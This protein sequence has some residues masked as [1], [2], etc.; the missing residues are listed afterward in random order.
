MAQAE[1]LVLALHRGDERALSELYDR[2]GGAAYN[3]ALRITRDQSTAEEISLDAFLHVWRQAARLEAR[4]G[5]VAS[6]LFTIVRSRAIDRVRA[7]AATKRTQTE[8][9]LTDFN[10]E[11]PDEMIDLAERQRL[12]RR[13]M[14]QLAPAQRAALELAYYEGLSHSQIAARLGEPLG[15]IK[16]RIRQAMMLLRLALGPLLQATP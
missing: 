10:V 15:T 3:L 11:T 13:A 7:R 4:R 16:T 5:S 12:V 2:Y 14:A 1:E 9:P 6:W 8:D